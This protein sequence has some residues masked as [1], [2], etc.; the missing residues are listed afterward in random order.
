MT[1]VTSKEILVIDGKDFARGAA[2]GRFALD[3]FFAPLNTSYGINLTY[4]PGALYGQPEET[5]LGVTSSGE[6]V[7]TAKGGGT[8]LSLGY[9]NN[10][11]VTESAKFY[12]Y[13]GGSTMTLGAT[14]G[15]GKQYVKG[16]TD[17]VFYKENLFTT[18]S[19]DITLATLTTYAITAVN[20][21]WWTSTMG[22][23]SLTSIF[24]HPMIIYEDI[25]WIADGKY[26]H[27]WDGTTATS[28]A[29]TL[30]D[31][32][33]ITALGVD[34]SSGR[35]MIA[36]TQGANASGSHPRINKISFW[37]GTSSK[38][39][40]SVIVDEMV[41]GFHTMGGTVYVGYSRS[42][43]YWNGSGVSWLR[44]LNNVNGYSSVNLPS[45]HNLT[46]VE[47]TLYFVDGIQVWA[48]GSVLAGYP[49]VF[50]PVYSPPN[51]GSAPVR[52]STIQNFAQGFLG[53]SH[54]TGS[55]T[56]YMMKFPT[57]NLT[58]GSSKDARISILTSFI[59]FKK[60]V[61]VKMIKLVFTEAIEA[62][63]SPW[64]ITVMGSSPSTGDGIAFKATYSPASGS[65]AELEYLPKVNT[66]GDLE[67]MSLYLYDGESSYTVGI[68]KIKIYYDFVE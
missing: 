41:N 47:N 28:Q 52:V 9:H 40:R 27:K 49:K 10:Y 4:Q 35:M 59:N 21:S 43:G 62:N 13:N 61:R 56:N 7:A 12:N 15:G 58:T 11:G 8:S 39:L 16:T 26:L 36:S 3:G 14:G 18:S 48:Y 57:N 45:K 20:E 6:F 29:F 37:D 38:V 63:K 23:G 67:D 34:P 33:N 1:K 22:K 32:Q 46:S 30:T 66:L 55:S 51:F 60:R 68:R 17:M 50:Y 19:S 2:S 65:V 5:D 24:P 44:T 53:I 54:L 31:D 25:L 42:I 64:G